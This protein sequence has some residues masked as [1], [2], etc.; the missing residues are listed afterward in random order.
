MHY[1]NYQTDQDKLFS[2]ENVNFKSDIIE[3]LETFMRQD[4]KPSAG[5][6]ERVGQQGHAPVAFEI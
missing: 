3:K 1:K 4:Q 2:C 5:P 6:A